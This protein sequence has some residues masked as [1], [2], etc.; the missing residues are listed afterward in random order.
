MAIVICSDRDGTINRDENYYLGRQKNWKTLVEFLGGVVKG[1]K[2]L[3]SIEDSFFFITTNQSGVAL[4]DDAFALLD[5]NRMHEV[6]RYII[7]ELK[8]HG[9]Q[10]KGYF[11]CPYV[12]G[13][14][15]IKKS[16]KHKVDPL[17][18]QSSHPWIKPRP[19]MVKEAAK[20]AAEISGHPIEM[21]YVI[22]DRAS[23]LEMAIHAHG[24]GILVP[25]YKTF[26]L[27]DVEKAKAMMRKYPG[28]VYIAKSFLDAAKWIRDDV[29][30]IRKS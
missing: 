20:K 7:A 29:Q 26:E 1:I 24:K 11:A 2:L 9:A 16:G 28:M 6:N 21:I 3:N 12:D 15:A 5:E 23:D 14:Y 10:V 19:G 25:E 30:Q 22:G 8:K 17:Y 18:L 4:A 13:A 27:G